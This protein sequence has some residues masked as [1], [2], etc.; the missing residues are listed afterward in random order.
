MRAKEVTGKIR[1]N[2]TLVGVVAGW[3]NFSQQLLL[4]ALVVETCFT[5]VSR[6]PHSH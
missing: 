4:D 6:M 1:E 5:P 3:G 2:F